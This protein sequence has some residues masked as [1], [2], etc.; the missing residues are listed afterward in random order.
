MARWFFFFLPI[1]MSILNSSKKSTKCSNES[2]K[3]ILESP[4][5]SKG[6]GLNEKWDIFHAT[7]N[8][9]SALKL[10]MIFLLD[11]HDFYSKTVKEIFTLQ[12]KKLRFN[13][14][15]WLAKDHIGDKKQN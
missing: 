7:L 11:L 13:K 3:I 12:T 1:N 14:I 8:S 9:N 6:E 10:V 4:T 15:K 2:I 5:Y